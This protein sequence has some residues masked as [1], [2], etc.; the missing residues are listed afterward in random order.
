M[1]GQSFGVVLWGVKTGRPSKGSVK[2]MPHHLICPNQRIE[3]ILFAD[4]YLQNVMSSTT[5][6]QM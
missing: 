3:A 2:G 6:D 1:V 5:F 4:G